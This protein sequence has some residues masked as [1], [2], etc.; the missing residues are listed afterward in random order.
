MFFEKASFLKNDKFDIIKSIKLGAYLW[1]N[2]NYFNI[3]NYHLSEYIDGKEIHE[4]WKF[5]PNTNNLYKVSSFGRLLSYRNYPFIS[6][7]NINACGNDYLITPLYLN[8]GIFY[9]R[10]HQLVAKT[11]IPNPNNLPQINH[12]NEIKWDNRVNNLEWCDQT[13]N[14]IFNNRHLKVAA[15]K[16]LPVDSFD[17][18]TGKF[19]KHYESIK[20]ASIECGVTATA[21]VSAIKGRTKKAANLKWKYSNQKGS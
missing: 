17:N 5:I 6:L 3:P 20:D 13:Y 9:S 2:Y 10:M 8:N 14:N 11:F 18:E 21:I 16:S 7:R 1:K 4:K 19:V 12:K 15:K